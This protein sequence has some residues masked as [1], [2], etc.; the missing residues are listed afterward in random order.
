[1]RFYRLQ[2]LWTGEVVEPVETQALPRLGEHRMCLQLAE[3]MNAE[4]SAG[5]R[6]VRECH[7][8]E[9]QQYVVIDL[10]DG[11]SI[12]VESPDSESRDSL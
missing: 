11:H 1:M 8:G 12:M 10:E 9:V 5:S 7:G 3:M 4:H 2:N 6:H